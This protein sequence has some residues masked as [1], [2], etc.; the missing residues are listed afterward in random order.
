MNVALT[1]PQQY[2]LR[3]ILHGAGRTIIYRNDV[4]EV[5]ETREHLRQLLPL[6]TGRAFWVP[7][8]ADNRKEFLSHRRQE[9]RFR[10]KGSIYGRQ[11]API[12]M[13]DA[14]PEGYVAVPLPE[15][16]VL[17]VDHAIELVKR[18]G[19][20]PMA[21]F[22]SITRTHRP[23]RDRGRL[24]TNHDGDNVDADVAA[25]GI[26][27]EGR[28]GWRAVPLH[29][30]SSIVQ[31]IPLLLAPALRTTS[32]SYISE[33]EFHKRLEEA[34]E[35]VRQMMYELV[36]AHQGQSKAASEDLV[37]L[38]KVLSKM[39]GS[40][41]LR[42]ATAAAV[43]GADLGKV[44]NRFQVP[45]KQLQRAVDWAL[46]QIHEM[47]MPAKTLGIREVGGS[48]K[49]PSNAGSRSSVGDFALQRS[50]KC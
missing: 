1:I 7:R 6:D 5:L 44:A 47:R 17:T 33:G 10:G 36:Y 40:H 35:W 13:G 50:Q 41:A 43:Q 48:E 8:K 49:V 19:Y 46:H 16:N 30:R 42:A 29:E 25:F 24:G 14:R 4:C 34:D 37:A 31:P 15:S 45:Q 12:W 20:D 2:L 22:T 32:G 28:P 26:S 9:R 39:R 23:V 3:V 21:A 11:P 18:W 27:R 38:R